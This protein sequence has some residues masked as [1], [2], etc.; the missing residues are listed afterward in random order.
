MRNLR[1]FLL[2]TFLAT[3]LSV[4]GQAFAQDASKQATAQALF[5]E[6]LRLFS[7]S[8]FDESCVKFEAS[9]ALVPAMGTRG[10]LAE[11]YEKVGRTASAWAAYREVAVLARRAGQP[12]REEVASERAARLEAILSYLT[13]A[14]SADAQIDGLRIVHNGT[15]LSRGAYGTA[16]A[17]DPGPQSIVVSAEGYKPQ[18]LT[19]EVVDGERSTVEIPALEALPPAEVSTPNLLGQSEP[20]ENKSNVRKIA[21]ISTMAAGGSVLVLSAVLGLTAK[22]NYDAAFD[23]GLCDSNNAC[24][25]DGITEVD[26]ARSLANIG[27]VLAISG[28]A[29]VGVGTYLWLSSPSSSEKQRQAIRLAPT[30]SHKNLGFS[31]SGHF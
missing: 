15:A 24:M 23:D 27:T 30:A 7:T 1:V 29:L 6:G 31:L 17:T 3:L 12:R 5:D 11:C 22:S 16:I 21:G 14:V 13:I 25:P 4:P 28:V 18:T 20:S 2:L 26:D 19:H 10:K 9:L 8:R